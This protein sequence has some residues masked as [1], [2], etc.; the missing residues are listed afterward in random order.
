MPKTMV[1]IVQARM[2]SSRLPGKVLMDLG[3]KT[4]LS[5]VVQRL[6]RTPHMNEIVVATSEMASDDPLV[7]RCAAL[8]VQCFRGSEHDVLD[9]F[10]GAARAHHADAVVRIT[11]DCPLI[12]PTLVAETMRVFESERADYASNSI[13]RTYPRGL[14][15]EVCTMQALSSAWENARQPYEREHVT[16]YLYEHP[17][18]FRIASV[19]GAVD[20]SQ[21]RWTLDTEEDLALLRAIYQAFDNQDNFPWQ[22]VIALMEREP[23][24]AEMNCNV[25]QKSLY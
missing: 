9:R 15:A 13:E 6:Q 16:P 18:R 8:S 21:Y 10:Y 25:T 24:L 22:D 11:A 14:D 20:Y 12:D 1:A 17:E 19:V 5:R 23:Q 7:E 3:G 4:V 2:G